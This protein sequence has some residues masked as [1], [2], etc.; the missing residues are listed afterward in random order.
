MAG[1]GETCTHVAAVLFYLEALYRIQ[2]NETCTQRRCEW[3]MPKFQKDMD[4]LPVK[5]IDFT[6]AKGK[7]TKLNEVIED[8]SLAFQKEA[9]GSASQM[10]VSCSEEDKRSLF[11]MLSE[12][13]TKP[14]ILSLISGYSDSYVPK[15]SLP[16]FPE[17]L[18]TLYNPNFLKL[19][20]T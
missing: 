2:G 16:E 12:S 19:S 13:G 14:A 1:L 4:Y 9:S 10:S 20:Y 18:L 5:C 3:L 7:K 11:K 17:P 6:S 8:S 15:T